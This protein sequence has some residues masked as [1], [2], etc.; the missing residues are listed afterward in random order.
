MQLDWLNHSNHSFNGQETVR[1]GTLVINLFC[2]FFLKK[3]IIFVHTSPLNIQMR[4]LVR[5]NK[6]VTVN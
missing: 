2:F 1:K 3:A 5:P 6:Y 4:E